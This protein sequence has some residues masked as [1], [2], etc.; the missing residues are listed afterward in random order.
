MYN[1]VLLKIFA[2][3]GER[4]P[5]LLKNL[6][7]REYLATGTKLKEFLASQGKDTTGLDKKLLNDFMFYVPLAPVDCEIRENTAILSVKV[8]YSTAFL[9]RIADGSS[10]QTSASHWNTIG[11]NIFS[12]QWKFAEGSGVATFMFA[13]QDGGWK[14]HNTLFSVEPLKLSEKNSVFELLKTL[15]VEN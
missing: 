1:Q 8:A 13:R 2:V 5:N 3:V 7:S 15:A 6:I 4:D 14:L 12:D 10:V 11:G 9:K